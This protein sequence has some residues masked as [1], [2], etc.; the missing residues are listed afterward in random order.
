[1]YVHL[2]YILMYRPHNDTDGVNRRKHGCGGG[3]GQSGRHH[4]SQTGIVDGMVIVVAG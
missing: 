3:G 2:R 1:M 4:R